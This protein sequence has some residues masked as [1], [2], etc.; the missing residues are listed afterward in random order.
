[1]SDLILAEHIAD[2][3]LTIRGQRVMLDADLAAL[4]GVEVRALNQAVRRNLA[5]FPEDF[6][7][8][9]TAEEWASLRSQSVILKARGQHRKYLP[10]AFTEHGAVMLASVLN[11]PIAVEASIQVVRAFVRMRRLVAFEAEIRQRFQVLE[12]T[13]GEH[14]VHIAALYQAIQ[15][16]MSPP[17]TE[18]KRIGFRPDDA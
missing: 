12:A 6:A 5:R 1:M 13:A 18:V 16:L 3:I 2:A 8:P 11:S 4:Y 14:T 17:D 7:F 10:F 15:D 9:L